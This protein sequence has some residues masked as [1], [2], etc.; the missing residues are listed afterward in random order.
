MT[1]TEMYEKSFKRPSNYFKLS[2]ERQWEIDSRLGI[3]DWKGDK[4]TSEE[5]KRFQDHYRNKKDA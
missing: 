3:L 2:G 1:E 5:Q 4:L